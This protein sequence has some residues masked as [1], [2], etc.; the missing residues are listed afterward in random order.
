MLNDMCSGFPVA[1]WAFEATSLLRALTRVPSRCSARATPTFHLGVAAY[2]PL[3][4]THMARDRPVCAP[5]TL[6]ESGWASCVARASR[7]CTNP[8]GT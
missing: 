2:H 1:P 6:G 3:P 8:S 7:I 5:R 4:Q